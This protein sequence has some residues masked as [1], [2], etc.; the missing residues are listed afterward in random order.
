MLPVG[1]G[2]GGIIVVVL[3]LLLGGGGGGGGGFDVDN[4]FEQ[5]PSQA[6]PTGDG[7]AVPGAPDPESDL[8]DFVSF[9]MGDLQK[10]WA[11]D[12][13]RAGR[14]YERTQLVL[15]RQATQTGCGT[16]R[17]GDRAV[18]LPGRP[19]RLPRP[20]LLPRPRQ[21]F[22]APATSRRPT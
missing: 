6:Q 10:F 3:V 5:F 15:F 19:A 2:L 12:F 7:R 8:V 14:N 22:G 20:R 9:V 16:G 13:Q 21:R 11:E 4:P 18:L 17:L 1:G